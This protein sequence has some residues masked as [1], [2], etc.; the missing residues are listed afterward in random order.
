[1]PSIDPTP[2]P[3]QRLARR[4]ALAAGLATVAATTSCAS[5]S[6]PMVIAITGRS[7]AT[8][9]IF[10][11]VRPVEA[12]TRLLDLQTKLPTR[13][14]V[15]L[16]QVASIR[17]VI[18]LASRREVEAAVVPKGATL[19]DRAREWVRADSDM[20]GPW[21]PTGILIG[22]PVG[23]E[24]PLTLVIRQS[25]MNEV[26]DRDGYWTGAKRPPVFGH[27][28]PPVGVPTTMVIKDIAPDISPALPARFGALPL[29]DPN[30]WVAFPSDEAI[31]TAIVDDRCDVAMLNPE[32]IAIARKVAPIGFEMQVHASRPDGWARNACPVLIGN[33]LPKP[34]G[35]WIRA[36]RDGLRGPGGTD[37]YRLAFPERDPFTLAIASKVATTPK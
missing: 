36:I 11:L 9:S 3:T 32:A 23:D 33:D 17:G 25:V 21:P 30:R 13:P 24:V 6:R 5:P 22:D 16:R 34:L 31:V 15:A 12:V 10:L 19:A 4:A 27:V 28:A 37:L 29:G 8:A 20:P 35:Q 18:D 7:L 2:V 14:L 26:I 1:M